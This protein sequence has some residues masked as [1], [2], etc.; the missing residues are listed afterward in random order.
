[1]IGT[2][3]VA[4]PPAVTRHG[5]KVARPV[6]FVPAGMTF[7]QG[8]LVEFDMEGRHVKILQKLTDL[9]ESS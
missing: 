5:D 6:K 9:S 8:D 4:D 3:T 2:V 1:M 7:Q